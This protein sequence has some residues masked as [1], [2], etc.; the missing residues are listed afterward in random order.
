LSG[1]FNRSVGVVERQ[2]S[3]DGVKQDFEE[4]EH[5]A[6][7]VQ[8]SVDGRRRTSQG[9]GRWARG[10]CQVALHCFMRD[11]YFTSR[12]CM[13]EGGR[14]GRRRRQ[15]VTVLKEEP[16]ELHKFGIILT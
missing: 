9:K 3:I 16:K 1:L 15:Q 7:E 8:V 6:Q 10:L 14:S 5:D 2:Q 13:K 12:S 11:L 4:G